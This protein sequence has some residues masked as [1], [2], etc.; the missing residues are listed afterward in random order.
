LNAKIQKAQKYTDDFNVYLRF[1]GSTCIKA[2]SKHVGKIDTWGQ[3]HQRSTSIFYASISAKWKKDSLVVSLF[4]LLGSAHVK[5]A[6]RK[7]MKLTPD[8]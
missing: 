8:D 4:A 3:F 2:S 6:C 7:L 1:L 5:S